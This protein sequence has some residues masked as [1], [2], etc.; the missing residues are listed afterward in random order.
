MMKNPTLQRLPLDLSTFRELRTSQYVYVDKTQYAYNLITGGRRFFLSRPRRFGKSLF[1]SMLQEVLE[2]NKA[3]FKD[4]WIERSDYPWHQHGVIVL[5]LSAIMVISIEVLRARVCELLQLNANRYNLNI[6]LNPTQP[7]SAL[8]ELVSALHAKFG[9]V[10]VLVD[11][12]DS[13]ILKHLNEPEQGS[14]IRDVLKNFFAAIKSLDASINFVFI[15]GVSSFAKAGIFSGLN[16]LRIITLHEQWATV[17]GYTDQEIDHYFAPYIQAWADKENISY[18]DLRL[19]IKNWYNGYRFG[20]EAMPV[21]NPFSCMNAFD[22]QK[23]KNF[24]FTSGTP[25]FLVNE[26]EKA[27]RA[28]EMS[29]LELESIETTEDVLGIFDVGKT[30]LPALMFQT[31]YL[32]IAS[33]DKENQA[34]RLGYPNYEVR[35]AAQKYLLA[36]YTNSDIESIV[37]LVLKL[38]SALKQKN[39]PEIVALIKARLTR[40]PYP[41]HEKAEKYY[42]SLLHVLFDAAGLKICSE[43]MTSHG[44]IDMI[45]ELPVVNY[46]LEFKFDQSA[47]KA[48]E[49]IEERKYYEALREKNKPI[50]L[51]GLNFKRKKKEFDVEYESKEIAGV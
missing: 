28:S 30:P 4:L 23:F 46:L 21:Y 18:D 32:T 36:V 37:Q 29:L 1:V 6:V 42:H 39:I 34:Y 10:A 45:I 31:G 44:R 20:E 25:S 49:Q 50:I 19:Q 5:D 51:L 48:L 22:E 24:W 35:T 33:F 12:Y 15:T 13:P 14:K 17:C 38:V 7:D 2:G 16:N 47:Q 11:E 43:Y 26:L 40:V 8:E 41:L 27:H 3:L 9:R